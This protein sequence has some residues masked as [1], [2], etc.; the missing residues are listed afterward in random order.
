MAKLMTHDVELAVIGGGLAGLAAASFAA[1]GGVKTAL[2]ARTQGE[3]I[4]GSGLLD[5]LGCFPLEEKQILAD[6]W[7]GLANLVERLPKHPYAL[8]GQDSVKEAFDN[9]QEILKNAGIPYVGWQDRNASVATAAGTM[10]TTWRMPESMWRGVTGLQEKKAALIMDFQGMKEF[11]AIQT[12]EVLKDRWPGLRTQ[13]IP[14]PFP[15]PAEDRHNLLMAEALDSPRTLAALAQEVKPFLAGIELLGFPALLGM[16]RNGAVMKELSEM[17]GIPVFEIPALPPSVPGQRLL[18]GLEVF[19]RNSGVNILF[20][21]QAM[22]IESQGGRCTRLV[23]GMDGPEEFVEAQSFI[24]ATGR[25]IG[26]GLE[27]GRH[28]VHE[29]LVGLPVVQPISR[30]EW[31]RE[32]FLD[33]RGHPLNRAGLE[34]DARFR[35]RST[36]GDP[37]YENLFA[38]GSILAHQD[39][40]REKSGAG[41]AITTAHRAVACAR[42]LMG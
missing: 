9:F 8:A 35:P 20:N 23:L 1:R 30:E 40:I 41:I 29:T 19:L 11:S 42:V 37:V 7:E 38:A 12:A 13:R 18:N 33:S 3:M 27:A 15:F 6:P 34:V 2:V 14:F 39:W 26:G 32:R 28:G 5:L 24:L 4:F 25:F 21:R 36:S 10:K 17:I 31:H 16:N 22:S